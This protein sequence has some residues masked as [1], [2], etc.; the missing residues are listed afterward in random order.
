MEITQTKEY[1]L[2]EHSTLVNNFNTLKQLVQVFQGELEHSGLAERQKQLLKKRILKYNET[3][4][5]ENDD[6]LFSEAELIEYL[7]SKN[8]SLHCLTENMFE[9]LLDIK[10][11]LY[12]LNEGVTKISKEENEKLK[13]ETLE[14]Q[15]VYGKEEDSAPILKRQDLQE[16]LNRLQQ[17]E[18][19]DEEK[20]ESLYENSAMISGMQDQRSLQKSQQGV[21]EEE[22]LKNSNKN[23]EKIISKIQDLQ[24]SLNKLQEGVEKEE[25]LRSL[26]D[27]IIK[28][29][30]DEK[31]GLKVKVKQLEETLEDKSTWSDKTA[32]Y[33]EEKQKWDVEKTEFETIIGVLTTH[34]REAKYSATDHKEELMRTVKLQGI[35]T[36]VIKA[37]LKD[38]EKLYEEILKNTDK[39]QKPPL[40]K[41]IS[42]LLCFKW[43]KNEKKMRFLLKEK[44]RAT[45]E[46]EELEAKVK[47]ARHILNIFGAIVEDQQKELGILYERTKNLDERLQ[48]NQPPL[49]KRLASL[50]CGR[51]THK[52]DVLHKQKCQNR[53][54]A[55][56]LE[57]KMKDIQKLHYVYE[58]LTE[59]IE[60]KIVRLYNKVKIIDEKL[61]SL[62]NHPLMAQELVKILSER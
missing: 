38:T 58:I 35:Y 14:A 30:G 22:N 51:Q 59:K 18:D 27:N 32:S 8:S 4:L 25:K 3:P 17:G 28:E 16:R 13:G 42:G 46:A 20:C 26:K 33:F 61:L 40:C 12:Y 43:K 7:R 5:V 23:S 19:D 41:R 49:C 55:E 1:L 36:N 15:D 52:D 54:I 11:S 50:L 10:V 9:D 39:I 29:L 6:K 48:E 44:R 24:E 34:I 47:R 57:R 21:E 31:D 37:F 45:N 53:N 56:T 62:N 60:D 2:N